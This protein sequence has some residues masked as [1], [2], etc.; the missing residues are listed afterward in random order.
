MGL[1][2]LEG[3][4]MGTRSGDIDPAILFYLSD[5]G[6]DLASLN[7]LCNKQSGLL[8]V[9]GISNDMRTLTEAAAA[10]NQQAQLAIDIFCYR[11]RKYIG[12]YMAVLG[13]V[14]AISFTG[15]IG[16][17]A[18]ACEPRSAAVGAVGDRLGSGEKTM[19]LRVAKRRS[20]IRTAGCVCSSCRR[21]KKS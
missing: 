3:L 6:Y 21:T 12:A 20:V 18:R 19:T 13:R 17:R 1:T 16:E 9:S 2:P 7:R 8:G 15:G 4:V 5:K 14:D 10:G 11:V